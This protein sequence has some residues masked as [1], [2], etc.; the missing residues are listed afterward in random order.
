MP[1]TRHL[2][3]LLLLCPLLCAGCWIK[4]HTTDAQHPLEC[5]MEEAHPQLAGGPVAIRFQLTN[6]SERPIWLLRWNTPW[7]G[8]R[9]T[10]FTLSFQGHD[11]P[12]QGAT[13]KRGDPGPE[14]YVRL[15]AG[16]SMITGL[17]FSEVHDVAKPGEY[18]VREVG[19]IQDVI[20]DGTAPPRPRSRFQ[21]VSLRCGELILHV[22][23]PKAAPK[24][25]Y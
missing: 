8:W 14:E 7:E 6:R 10:L 21:P 16:E 13:V 22:G 9:G 4:P 24:L 25:N 15:R 12:Y 20:Q 2:P 17:D 3:L 18:T 5:R 23:K 11:L 1:K 19:Q